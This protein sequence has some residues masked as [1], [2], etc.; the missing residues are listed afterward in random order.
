MRAM[1]ESTNKESASPENTSPGSTSLVRRVVPP[2]R[3]TPISQILPGRPYLRTLI[4]VIV[5]LRD[6]GPHGGVFAF[7]SLAPKAG[8]SHVLRLVAEELANQTGESVLAADSKTLDGSGSRRA[9]P[10]QGAVEIS[11]NVWKV[12][13]SSDTDPAA[14]SDLERI[15]ADVLSRSFG[16][17][18][19]DCPALTSSADALLVSPQ[20]D[21][22]FLVAAA[23]ETR[24]DE[25][26][27]AKAL[28]R[29][30][31]GNLAGLIL[32]KRTYPVP[33]RIFN[34]FK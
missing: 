3:P 9:R 15:V 10:P 8:V 13:A 29:E 27:R 7:T 2:T 18:L 26:Q 19:I 23:G 33:G 6:A 17:I 12:V 5:H 28:I 21:G 1:M 16:F 14:S 11:P 32:N 20:T 22:V 24:R 31:S 4:E 34:L 30:A 25:I